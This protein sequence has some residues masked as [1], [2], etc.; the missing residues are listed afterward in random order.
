MVFRGCLQEK[1]QLGQTNTSLKAILQKHKIGKMAD[2]KAL[3]VLE[4]LA[5]KYLIT[6]FNSENIA[7]DLKPKLSTEDFKSLGLT[8]H[9]IVMNL[10]VRCCI[11]GRTKPKKARNNGDAPKFIIPKEVLQNL[12][13]DGCL[14][15]EISNI[16]RVSECTVHG[17]MEE[18]NLSEQNITEIPNDNLDLN[19]ADPRIPQLW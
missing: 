11:F 4:N 10:R 15:F 6:K 9:R 14:I 16:L 7:A 12:I 19:L 1:K 13:D 18:Y 3:A 8:D 17:R 2:G 5:L